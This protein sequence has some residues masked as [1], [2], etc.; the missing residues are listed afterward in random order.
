MVFSINFPVHCRHWPRLGNSLHSYP[1]VLSKQTNSKL[2][3]LNFGNT[4]HI[5]K[6]WRPKNCINTSKLTKFKNRTFNSAT[7]YMILKFYP[8]SSSRSP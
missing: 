1:V 7:G 2:Y 6:V 3:L 4:A 5:L 8:T